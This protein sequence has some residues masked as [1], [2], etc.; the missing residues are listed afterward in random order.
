MFQAIKRTFQKYSK[1]K[2]VQKIRLGICAMDKKAK[3]KPMKEILSRLPDELFEIIIFGDDCIL[4]QPI[5][6]WPEVEVLIAFYSTK[7]PSQKA[8]EYVKLRKPFMV[9]DLEMDAVLKDRRKVYSILQREGID[10]PFHVVCD[11]DD[12][13]IQNKIEEFDEV[14]DILYSNVVSTTY[15]I[16]PRPVHHC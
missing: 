7:F 16:V 9:N 10:V 15:N 3:S 4:N 6:N 5:E 1:R 14:N 12:P 11:R 2:G 13:N 8:L